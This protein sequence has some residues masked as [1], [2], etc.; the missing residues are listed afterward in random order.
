MQNDRLRKN[1]AAVALGTIGFLLGLFIRL[2]VLPAAPY[3]KYDP[4]GFIFLASGV[5]LGP[6]A[7]AASAGVRFFLNF[8]RSGNLFATLS[9]FIAGVCFVVPASW[10][11]RRWPSHGAAVPSCLGAA[12]LTTA[13]MVPV[14]VVTL[15]LEMGK[16]PGEVMAMMLPAIVPFN[17]LKWI[18]NAALYLL[19]GRRVTGV[20]RKTMG[21]REG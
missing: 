17:L 3:L 2:P 4:S 14:N 18:L 11:M 6:G 12:I 21:R 16:M 7:G 10:A 9:D 15:Y 1:I 5:L 13:V 20:V 8:T 19:I